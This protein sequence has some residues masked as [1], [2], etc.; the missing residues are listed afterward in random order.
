MLCRL[1]GSLFLML[2]SVRFFRISLFYNSFPLSP[3]SRIALTPA[4]LLLLHLTFL[5]FPI[6]VCYSYSPAFYV[7][8][9]LSGL[10]FSYFKL[11]LLRLATDWRI[12]KACDPS[13]NIITTLLACFV[14]NLVKR[15][16]TISGG[17]CN[18]ITFAISLPAPLTSLFHFWPSILSHAETF[19]PPRVRCDRARDRWAPLF[20]CERQCMRVSHPS[21]SWTDGQAKM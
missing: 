13:P 17:D 3:R 21:G 16:G 12:F 8:G 10:H 5:L 9:Y 15:M 14:K 20:V 6:C 2:V 18:T 11:P 7:F 19:F 4:S 1:C